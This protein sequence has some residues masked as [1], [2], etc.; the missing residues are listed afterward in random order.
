MPMAPVAFSAAPSTMSFLL[1]PGERGTG[2]V[3]RSHFLQ[4]AVRAVR[5]AGPG[6]RLDEMSDSESDVPLANRTFKSNRMEKMTTSRTREISTHEQVSAYSSLTES[7]NAVAELAQ[8]FGIDGET[9]KVCATSATCNGT[10]II[11]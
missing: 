6:C 9:P 7:R 8:S 3:H 10:V 2:K 1:M 11:R 5:D 4:H